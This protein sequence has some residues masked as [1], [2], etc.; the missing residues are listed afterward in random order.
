MEKMLAEFSGYMAIERGCSENTVAAYVSD[1]NSFIAFLYRCGCSDFESVERNMIV[2]FLGECKDSGMETSSIARRLVAIKAMIRYL[3]RERKITRDVTDVMNTPKLWRILPDFLSSR[4]VEALINVFPKNGKDPLALRNRCILELLYS[5]GL[6][7]SEC[8]SLRNGSIQFEEGLIRVLG[9]GSKERI[10]PVGSVALG[11]LRLYLEKARPLLLKTASS[12]WL[13]LSYRGEPLE[14][15]RIWQVV[16]EAARMAGISKNIHPHTLRHSFASH[17]LENGA[18]L[19]VIQEM[20]G[21]AD[22]STTQIYTHI[23]RNRL[24]SVHQLFHPRAKK[25]EKK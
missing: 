7:V 22:I 24:M 13:F 14:R 18:D 23:D 17:L 20:L 25:A 15:E 5:S 2:D 11:V 21:H 8:A 6:R 16:K 9:K 3:H 4:E 1:L 19:R 12:P 10:V